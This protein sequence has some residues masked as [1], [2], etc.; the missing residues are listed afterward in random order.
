MVVCDNIGDHIIGNVYVKYRDENS[1]GHAISM[2]SGRFYG[3]M[4]D[5]IRVHT[6]RLRIYEQTIAFDYLKYPQESRFNVNT[7]QSLIFVRLV[8]VSLWTVSV[9]VEAIATSC[10]S[11]MFLVPY[12]GN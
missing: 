10:I 2:L 6:I 4:L 9:D 5:N 8:A 12:D 3:G 7:R 11:S 1:A